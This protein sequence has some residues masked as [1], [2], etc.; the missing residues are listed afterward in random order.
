MNSIIELCLTVIQTDTLVT[1]FSPSLNF[2]FG[3]IL[4]KV[5]TE[6]IF[7]GYSYKEIKVRQN[8][9]FKTYSFH[10]KILP[11]GF[12]YFCNTTPKNEPSNRKIL[13]LAYGQCVNK[14]CTTCTGCAL[15]MQ[16]VLEAQNTEV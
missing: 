6:G 16:K 2:Q 3:P 9:F 4:G 8:L 15:S 14:V 13:I 10:Y 12:H 7:F 11:M 5:Q 1:V